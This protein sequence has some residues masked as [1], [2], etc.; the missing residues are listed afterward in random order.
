MKKDTKQ[1]IIE[2]A[3]KLFHEQGYANVSVR[4]IADELNISVGNL[5]YH[6]KKKEDLIEAV[7]IDQYENFQVPATPTTISE[8]NDFFLLGVSHQKQEDYFFAHYG[9]LASISPKVYEVQ[10]AA[11]QKRKQKL[12]VALQNLQRNGDM[13]PEEVPGQIN[14]LIDVLNMIKIYWTPNQEAFTNAKESPFDCLWS[15][16]YPRLTAKGKATFQEDIQT[17]NIA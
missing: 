4:N 14:A 5:T 2:T 9:E 3:F 17:R 10:V 16:I 1:E 13:L 12:Q 15:L 11:I 6:F 7:I 8:L